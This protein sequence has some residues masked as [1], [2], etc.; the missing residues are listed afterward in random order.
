MKLKSS[1]RT[2]LKSSALAS[3]F[4]FLPR[5]RAAES[6]ETNEVIQK[7][8]RAALAVLKPT[9]AQLERGLKLHQESLVFDTYSFA[10]RCAVDG[11]AMAKLAQENASAVEI[12]DARERMMMI[13][14]VD[15]AA[16]RDEYMQAWKAAGVTCI[17]Q[18]AGEEG[19][20]PLRLIKRLANFTYVTDHLKGFLNKAATPTDI[21]AANKAG[22]HCL[23]L[24]G[25]GVP[26][27]SSGSVCLTSC[28]TLWY[29]GTSVFE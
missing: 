24:T 16:E 12:K 4:L 5:L 27:P 14:C 29:S 21:I 10:P 3:P 22:K 17:F 7:S 6:W 26:L 13:R 15:D 8:R 9:A 28:A 19:Q 18:N 20:A 11:E 23:Y 1:R 2:F 25:N